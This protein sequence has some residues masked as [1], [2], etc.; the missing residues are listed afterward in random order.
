MEGLG[1]VED[2]TAF[3]H[4]RLAC[5]AST[6]RLLILASLPYATAHANASLPA[7]HD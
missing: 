2:D 5:I 4:T 3:E 1:L 7:A 6:F